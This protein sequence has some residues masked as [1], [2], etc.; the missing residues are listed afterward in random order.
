M[1]VNAGST[2]KSKGTK[3]PLAKRHLEAVKRCMES[4]R[5]H[6]E[7][8]SQLKAFSKL[9]QHQGQIMVLLA[10]CS[11]YLLSCDKSLTAEDFEDVLKNEYAEVLQDLLEHPP[12][13]VPKKLQTESVYGE[14]LAD[15]EEFY[16][17][18]YESTIRADGYKLYD[19]LT[20]AA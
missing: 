11:K 5:Q 17:R 12:S 6:Q 7:L 8:Y 3:H 14:L 13:I 18:V 20:G 9:T 10:D 19:T 4:L 16:D 15:F 1:H 2:A